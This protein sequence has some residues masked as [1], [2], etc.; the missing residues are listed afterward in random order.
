MQID[1]KLVIEENITERLFMYVCISA[2][3]IKEKF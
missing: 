1:E 2:L 3:F